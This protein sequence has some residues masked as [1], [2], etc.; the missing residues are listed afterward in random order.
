[1]QI[2]NNTILSLRQIDNTVIIGMYSLPEH[3]GEIVTIVQKISDF[4][5]SGQCM[6]MT[7]EEEDINTTTLIITDTNLSNVIQALSIIQKTV[8]PILD[9][10]LN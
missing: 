10:C 4:V 2:L 7:T 9:Y 8:L 3:K 5:K 6:A 1:M